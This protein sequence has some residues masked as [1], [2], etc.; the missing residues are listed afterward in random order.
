MVNKRINFDAPVAV[1]KGYKKW[2]VENGFKMREPLLNFINN[3][4]KDRELKKR[5]R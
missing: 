2:C 5:K 1:Y 3:I 4:H